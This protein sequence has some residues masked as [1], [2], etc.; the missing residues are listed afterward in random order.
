M[1]T[2]KI[3]FFNQMWVEAYHNKEG[4]EEFGEKPFLSLRKEGMC[5]FADTTY[6]N[7]FYEKIKDFSNF[8]TPD[9]CPI[10]AV[11]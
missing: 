4:K 2:V 10:K 6:R 1:V 3:N 11:S 8:P 5:T 7:N 9:T